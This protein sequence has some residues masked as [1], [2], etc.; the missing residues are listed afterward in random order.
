MKQ[1]WKPKVQ[2]MCLKMAWAKKGFP[3]R[4]KYNTAGI[5]LY[6]DYLY[7]NLYGIPIL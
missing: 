1:L 5:S 6:K 4:G 2:E 3:D 7:E